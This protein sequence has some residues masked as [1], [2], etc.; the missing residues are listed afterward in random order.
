MHPAPRTPI[1]S[2]HLAFVEASLMR[3]ATQLPLPLSAADRSTSLLTQALTDLHARG[4]LIDMQ[5]PPRRRP[6]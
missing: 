2:A 6:S 1:P 3:W 4:M 5:L